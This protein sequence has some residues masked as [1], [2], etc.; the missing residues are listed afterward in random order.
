MKKILSF[1]LV[2]TLLLTTGL[3]VFAEEIQ[4]ETKDVVYKEEKVFKTETELADYISENKEQQDA[5]TEMVLAKYPDAEL[6][7]VKV[8]DYQVNE[9]GSLATIEQVEQESERPLLGAVWNQNYERGLFS[10]RISTYNHGNGYSLIGVAKWGG[11]WTMVPSGCSTK[12]FAQEGEDCIS[13]SWGGKFRTNDWSITAHES[14]K[15]GNTTSSWNTTFYP[16]KQNL[17]G[18]IAYKFDEAEYG[19]WTGRH[20]YTDTVSLWV[21]LE[22][23]GDEFEGEE[24]GAYLQYIHTYDD[25]K[26]S[27]SVTGTAMGSCILPIPIIDLNTTQGQWIIELGVNE[28]LY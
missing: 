19:Y 11:T 20:Y 17:Y 8:V 24:T 23:T 4:E 16:Y 22:R 7:G 1:V 10:M 25:I 26:I 5:I 27:A 3:G 28:L 6:I 2:L 15:S 14:D 18:M 9:D 21:D 12:D 13:I